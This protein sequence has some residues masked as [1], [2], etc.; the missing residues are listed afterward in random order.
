MDKKRLPDVSETG[1]RYVDRTRGG[2]LVSSPVERHVF[3]R[4][5]RGLGVLVV[6]AILVALGLLLYWRS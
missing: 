5:R 2:W 3:P 4:R 6:V 1:R